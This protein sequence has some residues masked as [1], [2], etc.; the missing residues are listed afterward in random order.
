MRRRVRGLRPLQIALRSA[1]L[2]LRSARR[3]VRAGK[4]RR[5]LRHFQHRQRLA[6]L[7]VVADI[8]INLADVA[9]HLRVHID[10][11]ER[12]EFPGDG[13]RAADVV[14]LHV[15][16][17]CRHGRGGAFRR[18]LAIF[19]LQRAPSNPAPGNQRYHH[20]RDDR[21]DHSCSCHGKFLLRRARRLEISGA[22]HPQNVQIPWKCNPGPACGPDRRWITVCSETAS[23]SEGGGRNDNPPVMTCCMGMTTSCSCRAGKTGAACDTIG[24]GSVVSNARGAAIRG[25]LSSSVQRRNSELAIVARKL[26]G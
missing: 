18:V 9:R 2:L 4:L 24:V 13:Q 3:R 1:N 17:R 8:H 15:H 26:G 14:T 20:Q 22:R 10:V 19:S 25:L 12:L 16:D 23:Y 21:A 11:L 7:H 6:F 5:Q